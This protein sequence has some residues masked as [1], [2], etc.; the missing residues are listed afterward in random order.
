MFDATKLQRKLPLLSNYG[1]D[2]ESWIT[3]FSKLLELYDIR[4]PRRIF[5]WAKEAVE[6]DIQGTLNSLIAR[7]GDE[8]RYPTFK[9]IQ[10]AIEEHMH[11]TES[12]KCSVLKSLQIND[13]ESLKKFNY[14]YKKLYNKLSLEYRRLISI[15]DYTNAISS[16]VFP[17][18]RVM[19]AECE[20]INE[21]FKIAE[22]AE[23]AEKEITNANQK[24]DINNMRNH[25][26]FTQSQPNMSL[27]M[28]HPF[29]ENL[30]INQLP[31]NNNMNNTFMGGNNWNSKSKPWNN[32]NNF[33]NPNY[34]YHMSNP[35][36]YLN[37]NNTNK[38]NNGNRTNR[39]NSKFNYRNVPNNNTNNINQYMSNNN[40]YHM[41]D[42]S[43]HQSSNEIRDNN[44]EHYFDNIN[45]NSN[46]NT[47]NKEYDQQK[48]NS[49]KI[50]SIN[51]SQNFNYQN[52][53]NYNNEMENNNVINT[54]VSNNNNSYHLHCYRCTLEGHKASACPYTYKQLAEME[55]KGLINK[56]LN[57]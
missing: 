7:R 48:Y 15:K 14:R 44:N 1:K 56:S 34:V 38:L 29:Y 52:G 27:L 22:V 26:M 11:I 8:I 43:N 35:N 13:E 32:I 17:C 25:I 18:S 19:I 37:N 39:Y 47:T 12:D 53:N 3:D 23:E 40:K 49:N 5:T 9:E 24:N 33:R 28:N 6:E 41:S 54:M 57:Q 16:R 2:V 42:M 4:E 45:N 20:T 55:E 10:N 46:I 50:N 36:Y 31:K 21:A 30:Q 51:T